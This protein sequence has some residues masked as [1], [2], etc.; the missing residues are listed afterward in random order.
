MN[1]HPAWV[2]AAARCKH[3][4]TLQHITTVIYHIISTEKLFTEKKEEIPRY[5]PGEI[6]LFLVSDSSYIS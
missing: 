1:R 5:L 2:P 4:N 3:Y 6:V